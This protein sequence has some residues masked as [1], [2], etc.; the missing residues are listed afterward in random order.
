MSQRPIQPQSDT[1]ARR[2]D[3]L[4][5]GQGEAVGPLARREIHHPAD[6]VA[7][8]RRVE[9]R[10]QR[11]A[12][13]SLTVEKRLEKTPPPLRV[14][15]PNADGAEFPPVHRQRDARRIER[16]TGLERANA[17]RDLESIHGSARRISEIDLHR[18]DVERDLVTVGPH[19]VVQRDVQN[20]TR[21]P[22]RPALVEFIGRP[23]ARNV[24]RNLAD[25]GDAGGA[26][27]EA[28]ATTQ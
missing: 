1:L 13:G 11:G 19:R 8:L 26:A 10:G 21:E 2:R 14:V 28:A 22:D 23:R 20:E 27:T 15:E 3:G 24:R 6:R 5:E 25:V 17:E 12:G 18:N 7:P 4:V 16:E 9:R